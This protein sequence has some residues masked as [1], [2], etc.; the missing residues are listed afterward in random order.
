VTSLDVT[1][2]R[3]SDSM[4]E[5]TVAR[6]LVEP[7]A[8]VAKGPPPVEIDTDK[9]TVVYDAETSGTLLEILVPEGAA[10][11][12][13]SVEAEID[14]GAA[15]TSAARSSPRRPSTTS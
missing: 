13:C 6:W 9:A 15:V 14:M 11:P 7:G 5:G 1:M 3:L 10:V 8:E 4:E 2:P 12:T